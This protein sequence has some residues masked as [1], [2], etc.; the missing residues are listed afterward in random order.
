MSFFNG[1][2]EKTAENIER[3]FLPCSQKGCLVR[4]GEAF[5]MSQTGVT[6]KPVDDFLVTET[7][8]RSD[9]ID[10]QS[11][12]DGQWQFTVS[13]EILAIKRGVDILPALRKKT[14]NSRN[15][16]GRLCPVFSKMRIFSMTKTPD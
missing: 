1:F 9:H 10:E 2:L 4:W 11:K 13:G 7:F 5:F 8:T 15:D 14:G 3:H 6:E 16:K 12:G